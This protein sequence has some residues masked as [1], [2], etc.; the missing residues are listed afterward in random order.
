MIDRILS[1]ERG[2]YLL[3]RDFPGDAFAP[4]SQMSND[5]LCLGSGHANPDSQS[6]LAYSCQ[7][8]Q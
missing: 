8:W 5:A 1:K 4:F 3:I 7:T 2:I 6:P